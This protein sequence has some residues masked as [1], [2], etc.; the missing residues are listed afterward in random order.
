MWPS[1]EPSDVFME[2]T[3]S[4]TALC[5]TRRATGK[6]KIPRCEGV[7]MGFIRWCEYVDEMTC[8]K[9][10][11]PEHGHGRDWPLVATLVGMAAIIIF[12]LPLLTAV[13]E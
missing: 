1:Q 4:S 9:Q 12:L 11:C 8:P 2:S 10:R 6:A 3:M 13:A 7:E 5:A